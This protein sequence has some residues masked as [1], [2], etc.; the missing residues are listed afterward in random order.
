MVE[1]LYSEKWT[2]RQYPPRG[3]RAFNA[4]APGRRNGERE[5]TSAIA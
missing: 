4:A 5:Q 3:E 1:V 2:A